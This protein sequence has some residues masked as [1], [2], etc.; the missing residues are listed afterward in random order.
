MKR[1]I[2]LAMETGIGG[3]SLSLLEKNSEIGFWEGTEKIARSEELLSNIAQLLAENNL[4]KSDI[5][6]ISVS[7]G[8]GSFTGVRTGISTAKGLQKALRCECFVISA[9]E[10]L[11]LKTKQPG[12]VITSFAAGR[13][14][15]CWQVFKTDGAGSIKNINSPQISFI[16][17]FLPSLKGFQNAVLILHKN[18]PERLRES[19]I[20]FKKVNFLKV[21]DNAAKYL[22][23]RSLQIS[24]TT[25]ISP[26]YARDNYFT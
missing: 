15:V 16:K 23:L 20:D 17:D 1:E 8:P 13:Q 18:L 25:E 24:P 5:K 3:G 9:L 19:G 22:G 14:E 4:L 26:L 21:E 11:V 6:K 2:I 7:R 12:E 10:A